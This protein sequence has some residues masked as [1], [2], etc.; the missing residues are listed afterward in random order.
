MERATGFPRRTGRIV[1]WPAGALAVV[2]AGLLGLS[3]CGGDSSTGGSTGDVQVDWVFTPSP[4]TA[5]ASDREGFEWM[6]PYRV[7]LT[8]TSGNQGATVT[9]INVNIY[10]LVN[11]ELGAQATEGNT[12]LTFETERL[13]PRGSLALDF[14]SYYTLPNGERA[15]AIDVFIFMRD[16]EGF[17]LQI[18]RRLA[19]Q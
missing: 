19:V 10:E 4:A 14:T 11:G 16:D 13:D 1:G 18:G 5:M 2:M 9:S 15:T 8:E 12:T 17:D 3:G 6:A 7:N